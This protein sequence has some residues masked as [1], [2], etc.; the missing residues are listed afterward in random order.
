MT[1]P[2]PSAIGGTSGKESSCQRRRHKR[3]GFDPWV[4]KIPCRRKWQPT[5]VLLPG[6]L[7]G[8]GSLT[9][10]SPQGSE[11]SDVTECVS[12]HTHTHTHTLIKFVFYLSSCQKR[13]C[14]KWAHELL[15]LYSK[16]LPPNVLSVSTVLVWFSVKSHLLILKFTYS[17]SHFLDA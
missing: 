5:P 16:S 11:E 14:H 12:S 9:R 17:K 1:P 7:H 8:Q 15:H 4:G 2:G 13:R 6:K 10:S 3:L